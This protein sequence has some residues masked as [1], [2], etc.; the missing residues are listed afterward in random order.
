MESARSTPSH[1][2]RCSGQIMAVPAR[3]ASTWSHMPW[4]AASSAMAASGSRA[5]VAVVP[6]AAGKVLTHGRLQH[7]EAQGVLVVGLDKAQ[8][9]GAEAG[10]VRRLGHRAVRLV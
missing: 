9:V 10:E 3:A 8:I 7:V 2:Q 5:V 4:R 1:I 6:A